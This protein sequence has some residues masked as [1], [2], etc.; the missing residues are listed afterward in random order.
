MAALEKTLIFF[1][2]I[3]GP[4]VSLT[5]LHSSASVPV[6]KSNQCFEKKAVFSNFV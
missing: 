2:L 4:I 6:Q 3:A 5:F 1:L